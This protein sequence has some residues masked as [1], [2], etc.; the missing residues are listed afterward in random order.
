MYNYNN[1]DI[2]ELLDQFEIEFNEFEYKVNLCIFIFIITIIY[3]L[4]C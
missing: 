3:I 2:N 4:M 1:N